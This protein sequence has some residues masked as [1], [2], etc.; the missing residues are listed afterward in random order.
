MDALQECFCVVVEEGSMIF[1]EQMGIT[2]HG[3]ERSAE[4]VGDGIDE[5]LELFIDGAEFGR[6]GGDSFF[7]V[8]LSDEAVEGDGCVLGDDPEELQFI[9]VEGRPGAAGEGEG[10]EEAAADLERVARVAGVAA[11]MCGGRAEIE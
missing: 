4:V 2:G 7:E 8:F 6:A 11:G 3:A 9:R 1:D 5:G 10:A